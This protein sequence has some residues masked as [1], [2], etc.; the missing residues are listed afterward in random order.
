MNKRK[1]FDIIILQ[2]ILYVFLV[3][4]SLSTI[5]VIDNYMRN[6]VMFL[7]SLFINE[8]SKIHLNDILKSKISDAQTTLL[9]YTHAISFKEME[10]LEKQ[11]GVATEEISKLLFI[12]EQGGSYVDTVD[13]AYNKLNKIK[14]AIDYV[15]Y[16]KSLYNIQVLDLRAKLIDIENYVDEFRNL[17]I[18]SILAR[19]SGSV[20]RIMAS[21]EQI[22]FAIKSI[23]PFFTRIDESSNRLYVEARDSVI[24]IK[25][26]ID[27]TSSKFRSL[28]ITT[29]IILTFLLVGLGFI[30]YLR[31]S[32]VVRSRSE[33]IEELNTVNNS[34]EALIN[35][36]TSDLETE[37]KIRKQKEQDS[38]S[39]ARFLMDVIE[40]LEH[41]FYVIDTETYEIIMAN[42]AAYEV[43]G[44]RGTT[45]YELTHHSNEPCDGLDHPC[46][47]KK[48]IETGAATSV[49]HVHII[50]NGEKRYFEV[51]GYPIKDDTGK[52][53]RMIEYSIDITDKKDNEFALIS[54]N[55]MLEERVK[56]RTKKLEQEIQTRESIERRL[57]TSENH[58]R[59]LIANISDV[60]IVIDK[61]LNITYVSPSILQ[62]TGYSHD[63]LIGHRCDEI[64]YGR[65]KNIFDIWV[66]RVIDL[67][68]EQHVKE[69]RIQ[70]N[71]GEVIFGETVA[72]NRIDSDVIGG[73]V[74]NLRDISA[75][76]SSEDQIRT[77]ALVMEQNPNSILITDVDAKVEYVNPAFEEVTGYKKVEVIGQNPNILKSDE[78][79]SEVFRD[80]W[81]TITKG[82]VWNGEFINKNKKGKKYIEH[83]IIVPIINDNG[84]IIKYLGMKENIT[85]LKKAQLE[86]EKSN[87]AKSVFIA[88]MSHEIRTPLNGLVGFL[89][90]LDQSSLSI[91][92][93][94]YMDIIKFSADS[95]MR[96]L[97]DVLDISKI[98]SGMLTFESKD[99]N[100]SK[101]ILS[102]AKSFYATAFDRGI[103]IYTYIAHDIPELLQGDSMR[104]NQILSNLIGNSVKFTPD[105]GVIKVVAQVVETFDDTVSIKIEI[106]DNGIGIPKDKLANIFESFSQVD[107]SI[108]RRY[109]G[110]GL[111]LTICKNL[112]EG[113]GSEL[114]VESDDGVGSNFYFTL[115]L[116]KSTE[117]VDRVMDLNKNKIYIYGKA[118]LEKYAFLERY[119]LALG[120]DYTFIESIDETVDY[121]NTSFI[122]NVNSYE[123]ALVEALIE[124][125]VNVIYI[126][127][128]ILNPIQQPM[129]YKVTKLS[130]P[131]TGKQLY[132]VLSQD[133]E[134]IEHENSED[135][136]AKIQYSGSVLVAEDNLVN[137]NLMEA[138][139]S[140]LGVSVSIVST[141]LEAYE[142][143]KIKSFD[144]IFMDMNM[145]EMDGGT[146][147]RKIREYERENQLKKVPI[148]VL[149]AHTSNEVE[150]QFD[151]NDFDGYISKPFKND[152]IE[153]YLAMYLEKIEIKQIDSEMFDFKSV[154]N[155]IGLPSDVVISLLSSFLEA[156]KAEIPTLLSLVGSADYKGLANV[157][158][159]NRGAAEN[160][161]LTNIA[162]ILSNIEK[163]IK[164]HN[165][166]KIIKEINELNR[167]LILTNNVVVCEGENEC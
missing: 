114:V 67:P 31:V 28:K 119:L 86:A 127:D 25:E 112:L 83:A 151:G 143:C 33:L 27:S 22:N 147:T 94:K 80:L 4:I 30:M 95:L 142:L 136:K 87:Q 108:T 11:M 77:L 63:E 144:L 133:N 141:G 82:H 122:F 162:G 128:E 100:I 3:V 29:N 36:R 159:S 125:G 14:F 56:V 138:L 99:F 70:T 81:D 62:L 121:S 35:K 21:T 61:E 111:G 150:S 37:V 163:N 135:T 51:H 146:A 89:D 145:P 157:I 9:S 167:L 102:T 97:N 66:R 123:N 113:M 107:S 44:N 68:D 73:V 60:I 59:E 110:T 98:G 53:V 116:K 85:E 55:S 165:K 132:K 5:I 32:R 48:V 155:D 96:V 161:R 153:L 106:I 45:C 7:N 64:I 74:I 8:T 78:T 34:Q 120:A 91:E 104:L 130:R 166:D 12:M 148:V 49:E 58:F 20:E 19:Q 50:K 88:N 109:G 54:L 103:L 156:F 90:L 18:D 24:L 23:T 92:Q 105:N 2:I 129:N 101:D 40:S 140:M 131:F 47:L 41:P 134:N 152:D 76:K 52:I 158:H 115:N 154:I 16:N 124:K 69:F 65:D 164:L 93:Q 1:P 126:S 118:L 117:S 79:P 71:L 15:N 43:I 39:K 13:V 137:K 160:L 75:R 6:R 42:N 10:K 46:P 139:L 17:V 57:K 72:K 26:Y 149:T 38:D 84:Q